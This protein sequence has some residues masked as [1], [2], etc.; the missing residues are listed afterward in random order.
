MKRIVIAV[1][2]VVLAFGVA[3]LA[4]PRSGS[5][6]QELMNPENGFFIL[7]VAAYPQ[8]EDLGMEVFSNDKGAIKLAVDAGLAEWQP[9]SPYVMFILYLAAGKENQ[10]ITV[11]RDNVVMVYN[12]Q[13]YKMPSVQELRKNYSGEARDLYYYQHLSKK[14]I[15][16]SWIRIYRFPQKADFFPPNARMSVDQGSMGSLVGF[17]T[18]CY[19]KNPGFKRG[20]KLILKVRDKKDPQLTGEVEVDF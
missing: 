12:D 13:E 3:I 18:R 2:V 4:Q 5:A 1:S 8:T 20:D 16:S 11:G 9:D 10:N 15:D 19:F 7:C 6:E 14:A 17:K